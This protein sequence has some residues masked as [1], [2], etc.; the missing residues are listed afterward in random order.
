MRRED[1]L[2]TIFKPMKICPLFIIVSLF[3]CQTTI[4]QQKEFIFKNFTQEEGLPSNETY[5]VFED[6]RHY[7]WIATDLG[8][9]RYNGNKFE[10]FNLPDNVV[11]KI[12]EDSKG[13]IWFFTHTAQLAY[14]ENENEVDVAKEIGKFYQNKKDWNKAIKYYEMEESSNPTNLGNTM[15]L[16][17]AYAENLQFKEL[18][19]KAENMME[20]F[21]SKPEFYYYAGLANNQLKNFKKAKDI[22][23]TGID[24]LVEDKA[25]EINFNIQL[26]EAY[27]GLGD[28]KK[29]ETYFLKADKLLKG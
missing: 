7:L 13:R 6:S 18:S 16:F 4:G 22:L 14:F 15:L 2:D 25:M 11:F 1:K 27:N 26:G 28:M 17:Q 12:K 5:Y 21:P 9:V 10:L 29:K 20:L 24:Y 23:E 3:I 8:V 19:K